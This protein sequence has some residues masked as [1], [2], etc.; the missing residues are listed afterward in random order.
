MTS[1]WLFD[2]IDDVHVLTNAKDEDGLEVGP[3]R[4]R[5]KPHNEVENDLEVVGFTVVDSTQ[6]R[7]DDWTNSFWPYHLNENQTL[8]AEGR[9]RMEGIANQ[10]IQSGERSGR[11]LNGCTARTSPVHPMSGPVN[12]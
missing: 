3:A 11:H 12:L 10:W 7:I 2:D 9:V 4:V 5:S 8:L 6:R 1:T